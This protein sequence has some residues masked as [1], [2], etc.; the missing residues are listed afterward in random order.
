LGLQVGFQAACRGFLVRERIALRLHHFENNVDAVV[1]IQ[2]WWRRVIQWQRYCNSF[3][4]QT[5]FDHYLK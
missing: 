5:L 1:K 4:I 2:T 3:I